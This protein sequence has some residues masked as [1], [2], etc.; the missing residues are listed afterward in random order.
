MIRV[1]RPII[2]AVLQA[3]P[4]AA[5]AVDRRARVVAANAAAE[6]L[7][8]KRLVDRPF[9]TALR[10]PAINRALDEVL[11][12]AQL[13]PPSEAGEDAVLPAGARLRATLS[14]GGQGHVC[15]VTVTR[16]APEAGGGA[17][18]AIEDLTALAHAEQMRRDFVANVSHELRTPLTAL[19]GFIETLRGPARDDPA[20]RERFLAIMESEAGRMN[21]LVADLLSLSRVEGEER[22]R[23][24]ASIDLAA[25]IRTTLATLTPVAEAR[26]VALTACG[27]DAPVMLAGDADQ[28]VQV[29]HNMMENALKHGGGSEV[30]VTLRHIAHEP[31]LRGPGWAVEVADSGAGIDP[32]HL[33]R[34]TE[35]FYRVDTHRSRAQGGTGLGLA[36]VKHIVSRHRGR[37]RIESTQGQGS[38][39][40]VILPAGPPRG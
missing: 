7:L 35:R 15:E 23:P 25:L 11:D 38:R 33:P 9:V 20:A 8:G 2:A 36:I 19:V 1:E 4:V 21:R 5:L 29:L 39:F 13:P 18:L 24:A 28:I 30:R 16:L 10:H 3:M 26:D 40:T 6:A 22:L 31:A 34:L 37:L 27:V 32:L 12:A 17:L 14:A